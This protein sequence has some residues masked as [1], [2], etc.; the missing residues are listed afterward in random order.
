MFENGRVKSKMK[1]RSSPV[2][3]MTLEAAKEM[4]LNHQE[5][6]T[7]LRVGL[8]AKAPASRRGGTRNSEAGLY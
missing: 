6:L 5:T 2:H 7:D 3:V 1:A 8:D 4:W